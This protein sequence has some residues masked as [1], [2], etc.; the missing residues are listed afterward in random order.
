MGFF[1]WKTADTGETIWNHYAASQGAPACRSVFLL[2]PDGAEP[3]EEPR[4]EGYGVFGG[5][6]AAAWLAIRNVPHLLIGLDEEAVRG[7][8]VMLDCGSHYVD[9]ETGTAWTIFHDDAGVLVPDAKHFAGRYDEVIQELG[10]TPNELKASGRFEER[11]FAHLVTTPLKFSFDRT[12]AY[13]EVPASPTCQSQGFFRIDE[14]DEDEGFDPS[15]LGDEEDDDES[16][17]HILGHAPT[18][19][20]N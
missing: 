1:S 13:E 14:E 9:R 3:I 4:Y 2:Q 20:A 11:D 16:D 5:V 15:M 7:V 19:E 10:M 17:L 18:A 12:M 8:G 6:D